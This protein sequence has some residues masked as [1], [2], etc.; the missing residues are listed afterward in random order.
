[1]QAA[2]ITERDRHVEVRRVDD[3]ADFAERKIEF[4]EEED[5]L[6]A[7]QLRL[8]I[9]PVTVLLDSRGPK[10]ADGIV[11]MQG[12]GADA[13][14]LRELFDGVGHRHCVTD[15]M[16]TFIGH[17]TI[18]YDATSRSRGACRRDAPQRKT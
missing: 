10:Q 7:Q 16:S 2:V 8:A 13:G 4:A 12:S 11:M 17:T 5:L 9:L 6:Q 15:P 1:D 3:P 14:E 18:N